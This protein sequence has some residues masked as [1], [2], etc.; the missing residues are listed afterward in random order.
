MEERWRKQHRTSEIRGHRLDPECL[1]GRKVGGFIG[2]KN[3]DGSRGKTTNN[4]Y[5]KHIANGGSG[6]EN[7]NIG[8]LKPNYRKK[9][10]EATPTVTIR[11][12][13]S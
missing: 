7:N 4:G 1:V 6:G 11:R 8:S 2:E 10:R 5:R 3:N 9:G 13:K 12:R